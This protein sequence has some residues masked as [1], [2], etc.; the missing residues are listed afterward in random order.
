[1]MVSS[2][3]WSWSKRKC[4]SGQEALLSALWAKLGGVSTVAKILGL[5]RQAP[6]NWRNRAAVPLS[7]AP[8]VAKKLGLTKLQL[9]GLN[10][11]GVSKY[12]NKPIPAWESVVK[13]FRFDG[14]DEL[15][16]LSLPAPKI[17]G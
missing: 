10:Y 12:T 8:D 13:S 16:I 2:M 4:K 6:V 7:L 14:D 3:G 1:M 15:A 5:H 17:D 9:L 11:T